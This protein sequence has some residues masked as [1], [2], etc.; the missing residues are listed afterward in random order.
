MMRTTLSSPACAGASRDQHLHCKCPEK[1]RRGSAP[2][3]QSPTLPS[4]S[5]NPEP[6]PIPPASP[7]C[8]RPFV[9]PETLFFRSPPSSPSMAEGHLRAHLQPYPKARAP[10][11][12]DRPSDALTR[13]KGDAPSET[14]ESP[15]ANPTP[16]LPIDGEGVR[17]SVGRGK[18]SNGET[19]PLPIT[20]GRDGVGPR[21]AKTGAAGQP[22]PPSLNAPP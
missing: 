20:M 13:I 14:S 7:S 3:C 22:R 4:F 18:F 16:T 12:G 10:R 6:S 21:K 15:K 1:K 17:C 2:S 8:V 11:S 5:Q 9:L 19:C